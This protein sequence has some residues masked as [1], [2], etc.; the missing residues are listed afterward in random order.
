MHCF[1]SLTLQVNSTGSEIK[2][3]LVKCPLNILVAMVTAAIL[4]INTFFIFLIIF[5]ILKI[6]TQFF[7]HYVPFTLF[8]IAEKSV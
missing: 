5:L 1:Q 3:S 8:Q 7:L 6:E 4:K 2:I